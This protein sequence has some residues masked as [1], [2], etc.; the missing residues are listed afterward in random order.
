MILPQVATFS[1][2][3]VLQAEKE[4]REKAQEAREKGF[5]RETGFGTKKKRRR[6][7]REKSEKEIVGWRPVDDAQGRAIIQR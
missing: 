2:D 4:R 6:R 7:I 5:G 3:I 1:N